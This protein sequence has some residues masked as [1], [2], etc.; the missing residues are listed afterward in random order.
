[1]LGPLIFIRVIFHIN[2]NHVDHFFL[3][4]VFNSS[5]HWQV[6]RSITDLMF[7]HE[8]LVRLNTTIHMKEVE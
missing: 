1:M 4:A 2:S 6:V 3:T 7:N 8:W 5:E